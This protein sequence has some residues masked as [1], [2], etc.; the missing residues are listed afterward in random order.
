MDN[1]EQILSF[2]NSGVSANVFSLLSLIVALGALFFAFKQTRAAN[3]ANEIAEL[4]AKSA[5][6]AN[7]IA[8]DANGY[9]A[10]SLEISK[11]ANAL[12]REA[13]DYTRKSYERELGRG[14]ISLEWILVPLHPETRQRCTNVPNMYI[15]VPNWQIQLTNTGIGSSYRVCVS[16]R[17]FGHFSSYEALE[18]SGGDT[19]TW[20]LHTELQERLYRYLQE[21]TNQF[22]DLLPWNLEG[23]G[24]SVRWKDF[25]GIKQSTSEEQVIKIAFTNRPNAE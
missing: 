22:D 6:E 13:N 12:S 20:N 21:V 24:T 10:K 8:Q 4:A 23:F 17:A 5:K 1:L 14:F 18:L 7:R 9:G 19:A 3:K 16:V 2:F 25:D 11:E 15:T